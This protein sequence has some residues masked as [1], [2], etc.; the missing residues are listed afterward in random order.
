MEDR[1]SGMGVW[2]L[3]EDIN[4][5]IELGV[6]MRRARTHWTA[7]RQTVC[8]TYPDA[9]HLNDIN[10]SLPIPDNFSL[11]YSQQ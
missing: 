8:L 2:V 3:K 1:D 7:L 11:E 4:H 9:P 5:A 10:L 6:R